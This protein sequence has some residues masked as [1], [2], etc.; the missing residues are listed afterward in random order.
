MSDLYEVVAGAVGHSLKDYQLLHQGKPVPEKRH[1]RSL[2][3]S[4]CGI[5]KEATVVVTK[6]GLVIDV[7]N[8]MVSLLKNY[9]FKM[10]LS[11]FIIQVDVC[12]LVDCTGSMNSYIEAVK[13]SITDLRS[14]LVQEYKECNLLFSFVRYTD[15]DQPAH[16]RT[17]VLNF[18]R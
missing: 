5:L 7:S 8:P 4:D 2:T 11:L 14:T 9:H 15:Y 10:L 13:K 3:L 16:S 6:I 12:F 1:G 18:T 17:S